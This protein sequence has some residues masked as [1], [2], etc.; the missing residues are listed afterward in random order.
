MPRSTRPRQVGGAVTPLTLPVGGR[1]LPI[2]DAIQRGVDT[3]AWEWG[4][5][6]KG[7]ADVKANAAIADEYLDASMQVTETL[8]GWAAG[9]D[10]IDTNTED[11]KAKLRTLNRLML[12]GRTTGSTQAH[13]YLTDT[14]N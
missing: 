8:D 6:M 5:Q 1:A 12:N 14:T 7:E 10:D 11:G 9:R 3:W 4:N 13:K 2:G